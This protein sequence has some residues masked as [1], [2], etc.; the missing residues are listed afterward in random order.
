M[1][2]LVGALQDDLVRA[3]QDL[4]ARPG[5][6]TGPL[7]LRLDG[8]LLRE[9]GVLRAGVG[10]MAE[11]LAGGGVVDRHGGAVRGVRPGTADE[12][13]VQY[14]GHDVSPG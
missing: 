1:G 6:G 9:P 14:L 3:A 11:D 12:Q 4:A 5:R 8:R 10:D 13:L 7:L 2:E